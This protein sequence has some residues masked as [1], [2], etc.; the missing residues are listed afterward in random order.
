V[1]KVVK[2]P[3]KNKDEIIENEE[4]N[5]EDYTHWVPDSV[6]DLLQNCLTAGKAYELIYDSNCDEY[7]FYDDQCFNTTYYLTVKGHF[8]NKK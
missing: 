2:F 6:P 3:A 7:Y 4:I 8:I 1:G 5:I